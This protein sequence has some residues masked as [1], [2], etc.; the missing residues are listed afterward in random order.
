MATLVHIMTWASCLL[1]VRLLAAAVG[2]DSLTVWGSTE[3]E[4]LT[5]NMDVSRP[6]RPRDVLQAGILRSALHCACPDTM[7]LLYYWCDCKQEHSPFLASQT[8]WGRF[9]SGVTA[10]KNIHHSQPARLI[11]RPFWT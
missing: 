4:S 10:N 5:H 2:L 1:H 3:D 6:P 8:R 9:T 11:R 7:G